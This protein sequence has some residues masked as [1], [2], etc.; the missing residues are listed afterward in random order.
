MGYCDQCY[1]AGHHTL[2]LWLFLIVNGI[3]GP[4]GNWYDALCQFCGQGNVDCT[5][6]SG[7]LASRFCWK[8]GKKATVTLKEQAEELQCAPCDDEAESAALT[9]AVEFMEA[10]AEEEAAEEP[11]DR[12]CCSK[13]GCC[14]WVGGYDD[15]WRQTAD[16]FAEA[17]DAL[18][19]SRVATAA[20]QRDLEAVPARALKMRRQGKALSTAQ[21]L[22]YSTVFAHVM[23]FAGANA[24]AIKAAGTVAA[25]RCPSVLRRLDEAEA[26]GIEIFDLVASKC[27]AG[28]YVASKPGAPHCAFHEMLKS[29]AAS[30]GTKL[31][32]W[33]MATRVGPCRRAASKTE[34]GGCAELSKAEGWVGELVRS[35]MLRVASEV[36]SLEVRS[37]R[38][39]NSKSAPASLLKL[40]QVTHYRFLLSE[41]GMRDMV[42]DGVLYRH[43]RALHFHSWASAAGMPLRSAEQ[44]GRALSYLPIE[45]SRL[46][47]LN[48]GLV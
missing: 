29:V 18:C 5:G 19:K 32:V 17:L 6:L 7:R 24:G 44:Y 21:D 30:R 27:A 38:C 23:L 42:G 28:D 16:A 10:R 31:L 47:R 35:A 33:D 46:L 2:Q 43:A 48:L 25:P 39:W 34:R 8:K 14:C 20:L 9:K 1:P 12:P 40:P 15:E 45:V 3:F 4:S 37:F 41:I 13:P 22:L 36:A 11:I 26:A